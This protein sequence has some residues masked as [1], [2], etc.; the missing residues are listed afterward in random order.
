V[1]NRIKTGCFWTQV[2]YT[3]VIIVGIFTLGSCKELQAIESIVISPVVMEDL[4]D[5]TYEAALDYTLVTAR[6]SVTMTGGRIESIRILEHKH[7]PNHGTEA[8]VDRVLER[9]NTDVDVISGATGSSK[10][11]LKAI[12]DAIEKARQL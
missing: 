5:G 8:I 6:V 1:K 2:L 3:G 12:G 7:G 10:V 9:Q 4:Q 11:I